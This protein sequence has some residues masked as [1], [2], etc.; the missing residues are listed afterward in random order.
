MSLGTALRLAVVAALVGATT[1]SAIGVREGAVDPGTSV[2][3]M[4]VV[5]GLAKEADA[6]L[7]TPFCD[8]VVL[9]PGRRTRSCGAIPSSE[10]IFIGYGIFGPSRKA[11]D[12]AWRRQ[13]WAMWI[14]GRQ[15][16][17]DRFGTADRWIAGQ[18]T[19]NGKR[20]LLREW[21]IILVGAKGR[22]SVRYR[23]RLPQGVIDTTW[24]FTVAPR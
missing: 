24:R 16:S 8:P 22:H 6:A 9:R 20:V 4:L 2:N 17:L 10:R 19:A 7:F 15:V 11:V 5:Q 12:A 13:R 18:P 3:G 23:T 14:D 1:A 21:S